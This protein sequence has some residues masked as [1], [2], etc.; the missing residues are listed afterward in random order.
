[1]SNTKSNQKILLSVFT[2]LFAALIAV[3]GFISVPLPASPVPIVLQNMMP[4][5]AAALLGG[6]QGTGAAGLFLLAGM[7]GLP[8]FAGGRG[9]M[10]VILGPTGGFL[11]GYFLAA[12]AAGFYIGK[13]SQKQKTALPR[14]ICGCL[15]GFVLLYVPGIS[16]FIKVT[17]KGL[18]EALA[19]ACIPFL[20]GDAVKAVLTILLAAKLRPI[21]A[22]Y[23]YKDADLAE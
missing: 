13:P 5:L 17:G 12:A 7:L 2:A 18:K 21:V 14:I 1:M 10:A 20:P 8:V 23:V 4:V 6:V 15:L 11:I 19:L 3:S 22:R 16:Q 9:G